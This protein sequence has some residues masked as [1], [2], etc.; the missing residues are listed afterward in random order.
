MEN[1]AK[2][3]MIERCHRDIRNDN[4][5]PPSILVCFLSFRDRE[6]IWNKRDI[7]NKNNQNQLYLIEDL[8]PE[9]EKR[10]ESSMGES[11]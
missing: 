10:R 11:W 2:T 8:P 3:I 6:E 5:D 1:P 9:V 7:I 4:Q